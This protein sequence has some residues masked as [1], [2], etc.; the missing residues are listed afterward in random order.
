MRTSIRVESGVGAKVR[1][2]VTVNPRLSKL[3]KKEELNAMSLPTERKTP[4]YDILKYTG[5]CYGR[6]KIGKTTLLA[7]FPKAIFLSTEAGAKGLNIFEF[8]SEGGGITNWATM[9]RAVDL[10]V[11]DGG[12]NQFQTVIIDTADR[13]YEM[14]LLHVCERLNIPYPGI[15][16]EGKIDYGASWKDVRVAFAGEIYRLTQAGFGVWFTS[17]V[18]EDEIKTKSGDNYS[19]VR[20]SMSGQGR[21]VVEA[22]VDFFFYAEYMKDNKGQVQRV[23]ICQGDETIW[24]GGR[25]TPAGS[26]PRYLPMLEEDGFSVIQAAFEGR[27]PGLDPLSLQASLTT[28]NTIKKGLNKTKAEEARKRLENK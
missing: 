12:G 28:K 7:S 9:I 20:P 18:R 26:F 17:H 10:L 21:S 13:A 6:E 1:A 24:A 16:A 11:A 27:Y 5:M 22:L 23:L 19:R 25:R 3:T 15:N 2:R 14:A 8:N 4:E